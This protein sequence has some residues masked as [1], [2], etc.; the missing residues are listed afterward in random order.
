MSARDELLRLASDWVNGKP[1]ERAAFDAMSRGRFRAIPSRTGNHLY[2]ARFWLTPPVHCDDHEF[3][4]GNSILLHHIVRADDDSA[5]HDHPWD[6]ATRVL[7]GGYLERRPD[8]IIRD[9]DHGPCEFHRV[10]HNAGE[11]VRRYATDLHLIESVLPD[12]WT[13]V[14][15]GPRTREWGF[16]P[17]GEPW[18]PW[19]RFLGIE[20]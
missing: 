5:V 6:F 18:V 12:T 20:T 1:W 9:G 11:D 15:T 3:E 4:S 19:R 2:L 10:F 7:S 14:T 13:L 16:H 8:S 17:A